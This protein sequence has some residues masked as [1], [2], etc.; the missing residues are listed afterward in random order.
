MVRLHVGTDLEA[1]NDRLPAVSIA[2]I[3][4]SGAPHLRRCLAAL[5]AQRDAPDF[6]IVVACA[7]AVADTAAVARE[8]PQARIDINV[9]QRSPLELASRAIAACRGNLILVTKDHCVPD[10]RWVRTMVDAQGAGRAVVGGGI[11]VDPDC[12]TA[13]WAHYYVDFHRYAAPLVDGPAESLSVC[14]VSYRRRELDVVRGLWHDGFMEST[15]NEA[16]RKGGGV[17]WVT[18]KSR[19]V[20]HRPIGLGAAI[21]ERYAYGRLYGYSRLPGWSARRRLAYVLLAPILPIVLLGR[22]VRTAS[23]S[24]RQRAALARGF[25][26]LTLMVVARC[27]GEWLAY[28][29]GRPPRSLDRAPVR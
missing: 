3:C 9:G 29:T 25:V 24:P 15:V 4:M 5:L 11:E 23:R 12:G 2:V 21:C 20:A 1:V 16:L 18:A 10:L 17:L 8:F 27:W 26:P 7:P 19:V 14:N 6:E 22:M 13:E 28:V